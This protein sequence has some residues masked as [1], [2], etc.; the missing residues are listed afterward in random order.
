MEHPHY[1]LQNAMV[2]WQNIQIV[3]A[4]GGAQLFNDFQLNASQNPARDAG[5]AVTA[6]GTGWAATRDAFANLWGAAP[7]AQ[8]PQGGNDAVRNTI[9][10][11]LDQAISHFT[12]SSSTNNPTAPSTTPSTSAPA[13]TPSTQ[14]S[15][16]DLLGPELGSSSPTSSAEHI[17]LSDV[18]SSDSST[19][20]KP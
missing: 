18:V 1:L 17:T 11:F 16:A 7:P 6:T 3:W 19:T 13:P 15:L 12:S 9:A 20:T 2:W 4:N 8:Q 14:P 10:S 5:N